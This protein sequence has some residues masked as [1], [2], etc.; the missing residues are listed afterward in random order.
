MNDIL[1][2]LHETKEELAKAQETIDKAIDYIENHT[3]NKMD[4]LLKLQDLNFESPQ[5]AKAVKGLLQKFY[6]EGKQEEMEID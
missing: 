3:V 4:L 1:E 5:N 6:P 2:Q